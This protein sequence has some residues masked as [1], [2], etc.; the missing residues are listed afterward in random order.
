MIRGVRSDGKVIVEVW[1]WNKVGK[2][3]FEGM[4]EVDVA[5]VLEQTQKEQR[6]E[7]TFNLLPRPGKKDQV[8]GAITITMSYYQRHRTL[9]KS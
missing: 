4:C 3:D 2:D 1:D 8:K 9:T 7:M 6:A 5:S